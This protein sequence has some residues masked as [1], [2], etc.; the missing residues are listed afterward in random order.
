MKPVPSVLRDQRVL[1]DLPAP[2][3]LPVLPVLLAHRDLLAKRV[4]LVLK[5]LPA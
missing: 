2:K 1:L 5:A 4:P 3:V